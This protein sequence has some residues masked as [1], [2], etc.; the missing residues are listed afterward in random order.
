MTAA[1]MF[2]ILEAVLGKVNCSDKVL[3]LFEESWVLNLNS[4]L[5]SDQTV[6]DVVVIVDRLDVGQVL[7][8]LLVPDL[9]AVL[10]DDFP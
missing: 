3:D 2:M 4:I 5:V 6:D 9:V 7:V 8:I 10:S 1:K